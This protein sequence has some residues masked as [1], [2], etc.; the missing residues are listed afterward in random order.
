VVENYFLKPLRSDA[1][2]FEADA[3]LPLEHLE[4]IFA[5]WTELLSLHRAFLDKLRPC[6]SPWDNVASGVGSVCLGWLKSD[7]PYSLLK[8]YSRYVANID[9][10]RAL[11]AKYEEVGGRFSEFCAMA[12]SSETVKHDLPGARSP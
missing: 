8:P 5:N 7:S 9:T 10:S 1:D 11:I 4:A 6:V 3:I 2:T 12:K